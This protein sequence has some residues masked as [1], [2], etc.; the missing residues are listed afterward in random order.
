[1]MKIHSAEIR[2][3]IK[4][5]R[6]AYRMGLFA[7]GISRGAK[8]G[9]FY[10]IR[11]SE[12]LDPFLPRPFTLHRRHAR[13]S[14]VPPKEDGLEIFFQVV[15]RGT[16]LL[17]RK[18]SGDR[19]DVMGPL[20]RGWKIEPGEW[21]ILVAGGIG[22]A[23]F[24]ALAEEMSSWH[25]S[26]AKVLLGALSAEKLWCVEDLEGHGLRVYTA[27]ERGKHPFKGT[28]IDLL[29]ARRDEILE[30][31]PSMFAC[32]PP[33]M[34]KQVANWAKEEG[35]PC[36]V[37]LETPM[38]CGVGVCLGCA[39]KGARSE[40]P[41]LKVCQEGPVMDAAKIDWEAWNVP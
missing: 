29:R 2:Y 36:Q 8:P 27:V 15:G 12:G 23:S 32:G 39:V 6:E 31:S 35:V 38:A 18:A 20:G 22:V 13:E 4:V 33:A 24:V 16:Q 41:Y 19:V 7:R 14:G 17:S 40:E 11:V 10:M 5:H 30:K 21:P 34:L 3:V 9:Q 1:M 26:R 28:V 37:A 25:R